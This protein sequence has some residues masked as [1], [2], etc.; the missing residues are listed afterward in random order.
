MSE[1]HTDDI[2]EVIMTDEG[3]LVN[4]VITDE[5]D[6]ALMIYLE[7]DG[8][9]QENMEP[10]EIEDTSLNDAMVR[11]SLNRAKLSLLILTAAQS[12]LEAPMRNILKTCA[13]DVERWKADSDI[14]ELDNR[15]SSYT[16]ATVRGNLDYMLS[17]GITIQ[18]YITMTLT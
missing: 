5:E 18:Q 1:L 11:G 12:G 14:V 15:F 6:I 8:F 16:G 3:Y 4:G 17:G 2:K 9:V 10:M 7:N 13:V